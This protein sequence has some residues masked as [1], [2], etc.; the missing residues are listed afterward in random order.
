MIMSLISLF[1]KGAYNA[2]KFK[3]FR[4]VSSIG[5][6]GDG[7]RPMSCLS[8]MMKIQNDEKSDDLK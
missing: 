6:Q 8:I 2:I 4:S 1:S 3:S 7:Q 5:W